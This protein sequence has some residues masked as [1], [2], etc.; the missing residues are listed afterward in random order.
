[1][2]ARQTSIIIFRTDNE[3]KE[4]FL[5]AVDKLCSDASTIGRGLV[6]DFIKKTNRKFKN[7]PHLTTD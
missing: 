1:M 3:T 4:E 7:A 5:K 2:K 6:K